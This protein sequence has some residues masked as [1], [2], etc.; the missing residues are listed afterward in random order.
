MQLARARLKQVHG[1]EC[2]TG[3]DGRAGLLSEIGPMLGAWA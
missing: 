1:R 3:D 2:L